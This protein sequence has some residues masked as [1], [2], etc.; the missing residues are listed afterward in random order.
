MMKKKQVIKI[1]GGGAMTPMAMRKGGRASPGKLKAMTGETI[2]SKAMMAM[3]K[4]NKPTGRLST[5]DLKRAGEMLRK[6]KK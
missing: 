6:L 5:D 4:K 3:A 2:R 1:R